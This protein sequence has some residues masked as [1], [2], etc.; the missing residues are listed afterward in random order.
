MSDGIAI[1]AEGKIDARK[2]RIVR[3]PAG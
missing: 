2:H 1:N 3:M